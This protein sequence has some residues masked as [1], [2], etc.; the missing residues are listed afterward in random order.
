MVASARMGLSRIWYSSYCEL[1]PVI[2]HSGIPC[3]W[4]LVARETH[5]DATKFGWPYNAVLKELSIA[6][7]SHPSSS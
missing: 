4:F 5:I 6:D 3:I 2:Q 7:S 1:L